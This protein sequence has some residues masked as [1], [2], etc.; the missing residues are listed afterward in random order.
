MHHY[1]IRASLV[2]WTDGTCN[3]SDG[4]ISLIDLNQGLNVCDYWWMIKLSLSR[5]ESQYE[6]FFWSEGSDIVWQFPIGR[7]LP[8]FSSVWYRHAALCHCWPT[9]RQTLQ[10]TP[11]STSLPLNSLDGIRQLSQWLPRACKVLTTLLWYD[12]IQAKIM[13]SHQ[14][15]HIGR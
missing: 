15:R 9:I 4:D 12:I 14:C 6:V 1:R 11:T 8:Y 5:D 2:H 10:T 3:A 13:C 7:A